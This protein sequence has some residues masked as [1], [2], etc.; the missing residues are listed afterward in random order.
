MPRPRS[1]AKNWDA[2]ITPQ[3][4]SPIVQAQWETFVSKL[5]D[6]NCKIIACEEGGTEE[7]RLHYHV[8]FTT[9]AGESLCR[10]SLSQL[11]GGTGNTAYSL[12]PAHDHTIGYVVKN[13]NVAYRRNYTDT[14]IEEFM[15]QSH[16]Y[17]RMMEAERKKKSSASKNILL[18]VIEEARK[19]DVPRTTDD[20]YDF[21]ENSYNERSQSLPT[22]SMLELAIIN[23]V[24]G[25]Q[26]KNYYLRNLFSPY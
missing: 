12:R 10:T 4:Q 1:E 22:R 17:R 25:I 21:I 8:A 15:Q 14:H 13:G 24:G 26:R 11:S 2:R 18:E 5:K 7:C 3:S 9:N 19:A 20:I 23:Y 16:E 6:E